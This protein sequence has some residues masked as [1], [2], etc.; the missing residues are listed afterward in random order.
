MPITTHS[1]GDK[2]HADSSPSLED[3][4]GHIEYGYTR[5]YKMMNEKKN[6]QGSIKIL[7][8]NGKS[9]HLDGSKEDH[10]LKNYLLQDQKKMSEKSEDLQQTIQAQTLPSRKTK[11]NQE[12]T[13]R[14]VKKIE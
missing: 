10:T 9:K 6:G 2:G 5:P 14:N 4:A 8:I 12:R 7:Q 3:P 11:T 1:D 13:R